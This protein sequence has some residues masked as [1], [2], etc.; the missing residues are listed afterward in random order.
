[1]PRIPIRRPAR[2]ESRRVSDPGHWGLD[3]TVFVPGAR[4]D[5][6]ARGQRQ[7]GTGAI[8]QDAG[9]DGVF[10]RDSARFELHR[11]RHGV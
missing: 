2:R 6:P 11:I 10:L 3:P 5:T 9:L 8:S 7:P 4:R 1:M